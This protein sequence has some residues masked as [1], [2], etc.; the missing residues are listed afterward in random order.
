[1]DNR[2]VLTYNSHNNTLEIRNPKSETMSKIRNKIQAQ[3]SKRKRQSYNLKR[4]AKSSSFLALS[5]TL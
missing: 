1:M 5:F 2:V 4:K 3:S